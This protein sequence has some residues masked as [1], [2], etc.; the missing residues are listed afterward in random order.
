[1]PR[2]GGVPGAPEPQLQAQEEGGR[3]QA[4]AES[5]A[6]PQ[7][8]LLGR[9]AGRARG[10]G[11]HPAGGREATVGGDGRRAS[12][13]LVALGCSCRRRQARVWLEDT[14]RGRRRGR[15]GVELAL[16]GKML[17]DL[18]RAGGPPTSAGPRSRP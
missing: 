2:H 1:M 7:P 4:Q 14:Y 12:G 8:P 18:L 3:E 10:S 11:A 16:A 13:R 9:A 6:R 15:P 5:E 17:S